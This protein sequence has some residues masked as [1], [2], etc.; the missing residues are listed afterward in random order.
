MRLLRE[1]IAGREITVRDAP[2][3]RVPQRGF[4]FR[5]ASEET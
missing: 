2:E 5:A 1:F 4:L 3:K